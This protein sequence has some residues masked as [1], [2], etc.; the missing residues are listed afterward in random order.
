MHLPR[1]LAN[2]AENG[3]YQRSFTGPVSAD[4]PESV[5]A[6]EREIEVFGKDF[7]VV[8]DR[9]IFD[10]QH[11]IP[12]S[13]DLFQAKIAA[14]FFGC[15]GFD[16]VHSGKQRPARFCL[17]CFLAFEVAADKF[18]GLVYKGLLVFIFTL[19]LFPAELAL[20]QV[21][22]II[23]FVG[24]RQSTVDLDN[25]V[26]D[27]VEKVTVVADDNIGFIIRFQKIFKPFDCVDIEVIRRL[28]QQKHVR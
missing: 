4:D 1:K 17:L 21:L 3:L 23:P 9:Q 16:P 27:P 25:T 22:R 10:G 28:I 19:L 8:S 13:L 26:R 24:D 6:M 15:H 18:F 14:G 20:D 7:R 5:A 2:T 11:I 12:G